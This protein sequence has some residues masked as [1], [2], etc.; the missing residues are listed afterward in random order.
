MWE[1]T[2]RQTETGAGQLALE[3]YRVAAVPIVSEYFRAEAKETF[4]GGGQSRPAEEVEKCQ[5]KSSPNQRSSNPTGKS[6]PPPRTMPIIAQLISQPV[7]ERKA[8]GTKKQYY[9]A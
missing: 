6:S 2:S 8:K 9:A 1:E 5:R 4:D 3:L 7:A